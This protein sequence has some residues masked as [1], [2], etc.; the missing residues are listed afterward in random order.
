MGLTT[1]ATIYRGGY[2]PFMP[3]IFTAPFPYA[4]HRCA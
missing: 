1:S 2:G 4:Y 3:G